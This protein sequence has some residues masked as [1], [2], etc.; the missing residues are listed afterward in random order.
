[1]EWCKRVKWVIWSWGFLFVLLMGFYDGG[2]D[3]RCAYLG[4][5][6]VGSRRLYLCD[7]AGIWEFGIFI[8]TLHIAENRLADPGDFID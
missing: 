3:L 2:W 4:R 5:L 6:V 1:M 7:C 8:L